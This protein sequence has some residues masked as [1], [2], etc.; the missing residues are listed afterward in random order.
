MD[1][2]TTMTSRRHDYSPHR[3]DRSQLEL[4]YEPEAPAIDDPSWPTATDSLE[5]I[6][7]SIANA[8]PLLR[9]TTTNNTPSLLVT[10]TPSFNSPKPVAPA[11]DRSITATMGPADHH[12]HLKHLF[13]AQAA[14][15][16]SD[17]TGTDIH[18]E[19]LLT[20]L[21]KVDKIFLD[22]TFTKFR[23][24]SCNVQVSFVSGASSTSS[25]PTNVL[26]DTATN[27]L[28]INAAGWA[29]SVVQNRRHERIQAVLDIL[30]CI[31]LAQDHH[32]CPHPVMLYAIVG[33]DELTNPAATSTHIDTIVEAI[34]YRLAELAQILD[35]Q[36]AIW[37]GALVMNRYAPAYQTACKF[38]DRIFRSAWETPKVIGYDLEHQLH[39]LHYLRDFSST[40]HPLRPSTAKYF[41][42]RLIDYFN[43][44]HTSLPPMI[45]PIIPTLASSCAVNNL[46][47]ATLSNR[48]SAYRSGLASRTYATARRSSTLPRP[49]VA[50]T[51]HRINRTGT[52][53]RKPRHTTSPPLK[54]QRAE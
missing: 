36:Y 2:T 28:H 10:T 14:G 16:F 3:H 11:V 35:S 49:K 15:W 29:T 34:S 45:R 22:D 12:P 4:D 48:T 17:T 33:R 42:H 5:S 47:S 8:P 32:S 37:F 46:A 27:T 20:T 26:T 53:K 6:L 31:K 39:K 41:L 54:H 24:A 19:E 25:A 51:V 18:D 1:P 30:K 7:E 50:S 43:A 40:L 13:R 52:S 23:I 38:Q 9:I 44:G 21:A